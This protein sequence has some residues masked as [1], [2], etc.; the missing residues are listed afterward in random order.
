VIIGKH[1]SRF[2]PFGMSGCRAHWEADSG[3]TL[4]GSTKVAQLVSPNGVAIAFASGQRPK[5][6]VNA[7]NGHP[8][9][10]FDNTAMGG[11]LSLAQDAVCTA[12]FVGQV[13]ATGIRSVLN[14]SS[15]GSNPAL[16]Y[17]A[18]YRPWIAPLGPVWSS[19]VTGLHVA[20]FHYEQAI[21]HT[22]AVSVNGAPQQ[23]STQTLDN[24]SSWTMF[25]HYEFNAAYAFQGLFLAITL[26]NRWL[27]ALECKSYECNMGFKYGIAVA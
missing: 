20:R 24:L 4:D 25:G 5:W 16:D 17:A 10:T 15:A 14:R 1:H 8:A 6:T 13:T 9:L 21:P 7:V 11:T 3:F 26:Y 2:N 12:F 22:N 19:S 27:S 23:T 18:D